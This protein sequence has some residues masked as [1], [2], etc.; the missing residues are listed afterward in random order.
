SAVGKPIGTERRIQGGGVL[1]I[2]RP[3]ASAISHQGLRSA[4]CNQPQPRST[5]VVGSSLFV[6]ARPP[7]RD[8]ASTR[9]NSTCALLSRCAAAPPAAPPPM[10]TTS[11]SLLATP[12]SVVM[13][14]LVPAIHVFV[15]QKKKD[16]DA[17]HKAGHDG[18]YGRGR[19]CDAHAARYG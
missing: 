1:S 14:G 16:V 7:S 8:R 10:I 15:A 18:S 2:E 12:C 19:C 11:V 4:E 13:A 3:C 9:R 6:H 5:G 17:R